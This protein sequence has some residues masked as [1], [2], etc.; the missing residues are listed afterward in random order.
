MHRSLPDHC[1]HPFPCH[2]QDHFTFRNHVCL[3]FEPLAV[4]LYEVL[5]QNE[6]AGLA[7]PVICSI[8][9]QVLVCLRYMNVSEGD[10]G[11]R[12]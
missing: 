4:T 12:L 5:R 3:V 1:P 11:C 2:L 6:F 10:A 7:L 8:A 9:R